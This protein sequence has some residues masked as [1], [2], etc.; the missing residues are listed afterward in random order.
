MLLDNKSGEV[1]TNKMS[2]ENGIGNTEVS[3]GKMTDRA[4][5]G[6]QMCDEVR[7]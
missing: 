5:Y 2:V 7:G 6:W 3:E 1:N 4:L